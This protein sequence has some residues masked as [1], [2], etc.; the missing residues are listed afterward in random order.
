MVDVACVQVKVKEK[1]A[2][3][4][5]QEARHKCDRTF[6]TSSFAFVKI[7]AT[8]VYGTSYEIQ[9]MRRQNEMMMINFH[10]LVAFC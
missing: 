9:L 8:F 7:A 5:K 6:L 2:A 10:Y 3:R 4:E 1:R